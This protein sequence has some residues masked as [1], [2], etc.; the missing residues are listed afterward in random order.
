MTCDVAAAGRRFMGRARH[1][2]P[3]AARIAC[4]QVLVVGMLLAPSLAVYVV[5]DRMIPAEMAAGRALVVAALVVLAAF[6]FPGVRLAAYERL[7]RA[8]FPERSGRRRALGTAIHDV[9][10]LLD[11]QIL[12]QTLRERLHEALDVDAV[13]LWLRDEAGGSYSLADGSAYGADGSMI[14]M[15]DVPVIDAWIAAAP[16]GPRYVRRAGDAGDRLDQALCRLGGRVCFPLQTEAG[17]LGVLVIGARRADQPYAADHLELLSVLANQVAMA[18]DNSRLHQELDASTRKLSESRKMLQRASQLTTIGTLAA[19]LVH[20]IR[21]PLAAVQTFLQVLPDRLSDP[22][23]TVDF[24]KVALSEVQRVSKLLT[25]LLQVARKRNVAFQ[26]TPLDDVVDQVLGLLRVAAERRH[27]ELQRVGDALPEA[28]ADPARLKQALL[29]LVL[30][31]IEA[32]SPGTTVTI[33]TRTDVDGAGKRLAEF[34]VRDSGPGVPADRRDVIFEPFSTTK[35][36]GTG[37]GLSVTRQIVSEHGGRIQ[38]ESEEGFGATFT[39]RVPLE[40]PAAPG[41]C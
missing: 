39:V 19:G 3:S 20:E 28:Q 37:L 14:P 21:N 22:E 25:E 35:E 41:P 40:Q 4:I 15:G 36:S 11:V 10:A 9:A 13:G 34:A 32:S 30:N 17:P 1:Q 2:L 29:N 31:A 27:V 8:I 7:D 5:A 6:V 12:A 18:V 24:R 33:G 16:G 23:I 26:A 38:V